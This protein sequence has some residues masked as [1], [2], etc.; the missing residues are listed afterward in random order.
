MVDRYI[1][2]VEGATPYAC[3]VITSSHLGQKLVDPVEDH[4]VVRRLN[5][6]EAD[7]ALEALGREAERLLVTVHEPDRREPGELARLGLRGDGRRRSHDH[8]PRGGAQWRSGD[9][10]ERERSRD[11]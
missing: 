5:D 2:V 3:H 6:R 11:Q 8:R 9:E 10:P 4:G 1:V 7:L